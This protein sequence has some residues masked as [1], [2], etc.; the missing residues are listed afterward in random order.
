MPEAKALV[1]C[2]WANSSPLLQA[3]H[4]NEWGIPVHDDATLF[5]F[6]TLEGAQAGLSWETVLRKRDRYQTVFAGFDLA[7]VSRFTPKK[8]E[9]ILNDPGV[10]RHRGKIDS[11]ISNA[12]AIL[13]IASEFGSFDAYLWGF[14]GGKPLN[15]RRKTMGDVP[16]ST[17]LAEALSK[18]LRKRGLRFVG[19]TIVYSFMQAV[20]VVNDHLA[21]CAFRGPARKRR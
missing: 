5:E 21:T 1:R 17:P 14:I 10:I 7:R 4:D 6:V 15:G 2:S 13:A 8:V 18:D 12:K 3:Y 11:T 19:P 16:V 9:A 20:G